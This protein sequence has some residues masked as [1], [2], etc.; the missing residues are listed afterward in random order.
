MASSIGVRVEGLNELVRNLKKAGVEV[1]DLKAVFA[2]I[3][4]DAASMAAQ[5][6]PAKTGRL[7]GAIRGSKAVNKAVVR[8]GGARVPYAGAINYGWKKRNIKPSYF[9]QKV[10]GSIAPVALSKLDAGISRIIE[11]HHLG[12]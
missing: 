2:E 5:F 1:S 7:K 11:K 10:D 12:G 3:A 4:S 9:M 8:A 6:A